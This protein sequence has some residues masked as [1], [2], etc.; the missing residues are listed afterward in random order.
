MNNF[1][2]TAGAVKPAGQLA[3]CLRALRRLFFLRRHDASGAGARTTH[4]G[5]PQTRAR[6]L[7]SI[8]VTALF[9]D[10]DGTL[11]P[12]ML[13]LPGDTALADVMNTAREQ[14]AMH[15]DTTG[16]RLARVTL[17]PDLRIN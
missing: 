15:V 16:A 8:G 5:H 1:F 13:D 4:E 9:L 17:N 7:P 6:N 12:V 11:A 2:P 14:A 3:R 10:R